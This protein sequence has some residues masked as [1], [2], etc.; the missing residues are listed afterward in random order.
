[1]KRELNSRR[2]SAPSGGKSGSGRSGRNAGKTGGA[3]KAGA[4]TGGSRSGSK[5]GK[6]GTSPERSGKSGGRYGAGAGTGRAASDRP[7]RDGYRGGSPRFE[8]GS[9][10]RA[11]LIMG[12]N[13]VT[14]ALRGGREIEE[15]MIQKGAVGSINKIIDLAEENGVMY[16]FMEKASLDRLAGDTSHQG[17]I[18]KAAVYRY[19]ELEELFDLAEERGEDPFFVLLDGIEDPHNLGAII[20]SA[21]CAGASGV[22]I[23]KR[24]AAGVTETVLRTSAGAAEYLP[25]CKV[26]NLTRTIETL[27]ERGVW[28][29]ACDMDGE[30]YAKQDFSG[31]VC[32]VIGN[33]GSGISRLVREACDGAVSIPMAGRI[34]SLNASNAAA[35]LLF[36]VKRK[37]DGR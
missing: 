7:A 33:E 27:K 14:E 34:D 15:I 8:D 1:M 13:P 5:A 37:R 26:T 23:P 24:N 11:D 2:G 35:I 17:I 9:S 18:A 28:V 20:R 19:R 36:E 31:P 30:D 4:R 16:T 10:S 6:F 22:I 25:V 21:E 3:G 29:Y 12:R 32:L